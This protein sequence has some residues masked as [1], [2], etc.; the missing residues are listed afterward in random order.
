MG[1]DGAPARRVYEDAVEYVC[2]NV[3]A[4]RDL[5]GPA[6]WDAPFAVIRDGDPETGEWRDAVR[7]LQDA[8]EAAGIP[9]GIGLRATMG[10]SDWPSGAPARSVG[11]VC[12]TGRCARVDLRNG[13]ATPPTLDPTPDPAPTCALT[14]RPMRLVGD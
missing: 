7:E 10:V 12:P 3:D 11:W 5:I 6:R 8:A 4:L 13:L 9:G 2:R 1:G 14:A